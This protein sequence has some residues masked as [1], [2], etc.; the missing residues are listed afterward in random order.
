MFDGAK[1]IALKTFYFHFIFTDTVRNRPLWS[2]GQRSLVRF[3][4]LPDFLR[5]RGSGKGFHSAS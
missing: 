1:K 3:P 2:S 5:N 4:A